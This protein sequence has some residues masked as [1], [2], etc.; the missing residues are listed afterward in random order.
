MPGFSDRLQH[1]ETNCHNFHC[2]II[3]L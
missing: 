2:D 3:V 1:F